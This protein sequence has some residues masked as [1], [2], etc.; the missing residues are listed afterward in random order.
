MPCLYHI[1]VYIILKKMTQATA[2]F[3]N[4]GGKKICS[5][6]ETEIQFARYRN[7]KNVAKY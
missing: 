1:D 6:I 2:Y 4:E 3:R 7:G 5:M